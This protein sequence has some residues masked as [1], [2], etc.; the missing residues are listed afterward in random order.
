MDTVIQ[1]GSSCLSYQMLR[2][3]QYYFFFRL[4]EFPAIRKLFP[5]ADIKYIPDSGHWP[6]SEKPKEFAQTV[7]EFIDE[8]LQ[9]H[10]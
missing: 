3:S 9:D 8:C 10:H 6:H 5:R 2:T 4:E 7:T 1:C